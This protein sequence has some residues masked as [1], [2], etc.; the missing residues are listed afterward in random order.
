MRVGHIDEEHLVEINDGILE[1][2]RPLDLA[3]LEIECP[4]GNLERTGLPV[5]LV[6]MGQLLAEVAQAGVVAGDSLG[7]L[8]GPLDLLL[9]A[10]WCRILVGLMQPVTL[11]RLLCLAGGEGCASEGFPA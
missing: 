2:D 9:D 5:Q 11:E 4:V 10:Y 1:H 6:E 3:H 7:K 8:A